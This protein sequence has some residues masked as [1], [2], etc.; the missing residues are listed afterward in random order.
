MGWQRLQEWWHDAG[1]ILRRQFV[2]SAAAL[3]SSSLLAVP[4]KPSTRWAEAFI[5][6]LWHLDPDSAVAAGRFEFVPQLAIPDTAQRR[7]EAAYWRQWRQRLAAVKPDDLDAA[8]RTDLAMLHAKVESDAWYLEQFRSWEWNP[9]QYN[10][11]SILD[12]ALNT[13]YAP[14]PQRLRDLRQRLRRVPAYY[15][16]AQQSLGEV[17][18]E[19]TE[20]ALQ[21]APGVLSV[22][23]EIEAKSKG[24]M[25]V[26][27]KAARAAV[28]GYQRFLQA[29]LPKAS[30]SFRIGE[31]VYEAKF[32]HDIQSSR[33]ARQTYELAM[34][35]REELLLQMDASSRQLWPTV[36]DAAA[37]PDDRLARIGAVIDKLSSRHVL[38]ERFVEEIRAQIPQLEAWVRDKNLLTLDASKPLQ[39]RETPVYQRGVAGAGIEAPGPYRPQERT[40]Y[41]VTPLDGLSDAEAESTLREYNHWIL[42]ILNIHEAIP[43]H[44]AQLVYANR[45]PSLV[46]SLFGNGA[47]VEGWA[48][49]S[50]RFM[51][52]SGYGAS[53]EMALMYGK[54][55][56]RS[57]TNTILDYRVHVLGLTEADALDLLMRQAF[58]TEREAK[59]KWR[60]VQLTQVQLTSYF[61]GYAEIMALREQLM[62]RPGFQLKAFHERFLSFGSAPVREIAKLMLQ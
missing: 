34:A 58:Q 10:V 39:V 28:V 24:G 55:H 36:M 21:Q 49:Y 46:K 14:L 35:R 27:R 6:G 43:G 32:G 60:R 45:S 20:L 11:A 37:Q 48:V 7:R 3:S 41:N 52:D 1:M 5:E 59:E 50:E 16:A 44:Y 2:L 25:A 57:V 17:T 62:Q 30:R 9:A 42:Q 51:M 33:S 23:D 31:A 56:L 4:A 8:Q 26:E 12:L 40:Y 13:E 53:P 38:R 29:L 18:R 22:L 47:M 54:W 61:S 15:R 19:H